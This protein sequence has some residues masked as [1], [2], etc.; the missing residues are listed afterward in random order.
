MVVDLKYD[1]L[2]PLDTVV[3]KNQRYVKQS[4]FQR[5]F[6]YDIEEVPFTHG[7][8][9]IGNPA[10]GVLAWFNP[11]FPYATVSAF[12]SETESSAELVV[13]RPRG[14]VSSLI[15]EPNLFGE[16]LD[17]ATDGLREELI[18]P[19]AVRV[20]AISRLWSIAFAGFKGVR[21]TS[22]EEMISSELTEV[23]SVQAEV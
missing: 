17:M 12:P 2:R 20:Q 10:Q 1:T 4:F 5:V 11:V 21:F 19:V 6:S 18:S 9:Y 14:A 3:W 23:I 8:C 15:T 22:F 13:L 7:V 16:A